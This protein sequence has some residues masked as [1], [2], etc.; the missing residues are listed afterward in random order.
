M[1]ENL[2]KELKDLNEVYVHART[3][4]HTYTHVYVMSLIDIMFAIK[5]DSN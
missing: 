5:L 1:Q 4:T 2:I 3:H